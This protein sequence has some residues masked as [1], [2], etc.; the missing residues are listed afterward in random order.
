MPGH[1][2]VGCWTQAVLFAKGV[3]T[4][5][6]YDCVHP[7]SSSSILQSCQHGNNTLFLF[8]TLVCVPL[9]YIL[10]HIFYCIVYIVVHFIAL[11]CL[12]N[13]RTLLDGQFYSFGK[14]KNKSAAF[15]ASQAMIGSCNYFSDIDQNPSRRKHDEA[16]GRDHDGQWQPLLSPSTTTRYHPPPRDHDGQWK[17]GDPHS[18][19]FHCCMFMYLFACSVLCFS[20]VFDL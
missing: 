10:L 14:H 18:L 12:G 1:R 5:L 16:E 2:T 4:C 3:F 6:Y 17:P 7:S 13:G 8:F 15:T 19:F 11:A 20:L 9:L